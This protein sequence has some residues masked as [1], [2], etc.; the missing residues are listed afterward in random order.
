M[1]TPQDGRGSSYVSM[2][3]LADDLEISER[4]IRRW[5]SLGQ[6]PAYRGPGRLIR[7][8]REDADKL[9]RRIPTVGSD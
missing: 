7:I 6:L 2:R 4:T 8:K 1:T 3:T 9:M 5:I